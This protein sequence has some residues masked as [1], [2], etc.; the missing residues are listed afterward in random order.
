M[1]SNDM[2][3]HVHEG[4]RVGEEDQCRACKNTENS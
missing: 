3:P 4:Y 1:R 2:K